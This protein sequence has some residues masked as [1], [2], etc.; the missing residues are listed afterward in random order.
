MFIMVKK[1][2]QNIIIHIVNG[3]NFI[4]IFVPIKETQYIKIK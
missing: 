4:K 1:N 3:I 2:M